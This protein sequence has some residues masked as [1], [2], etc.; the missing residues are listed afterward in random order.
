MEREP[1]VRPGDQPRRPRTP[2]RPG[3]PPQQRHRVRAGPDRGDARRP[4][5]WRRVGRRHPPPGTRPGEDRLRRGRR[6]H[7]PDGVRLPPRRAG[8]ERR[9]AR[10]T[11]S[12]RPAAPR[13]TRRRR[14]TPSAGS[15]SGSSST[16]RTSTWRCGWRRPA[17]AAGSPPDARAIHAYSASLGAGAGRKYARTGWSPRLHAAPL[18]G[19]VE[20]A[21]GRCGRSPA[22][23]RSAPASCCST[24]PA[25]GSRAGSRAGGPAPASS[26]ARSAALRCS[27]SAPAR[28][29]GSGAAGAS[30]PASQEARLRPAE[31]AQRPRPEPLELAV[32]D[33]DPA[34]E[35]MD[36]LAQ[37]DQRCV[38]LRELR[39]GGIAFL[40]RS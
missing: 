8:R 2:G 25:A 36:L 34:A 28:R 35:L 15:T 17:L 21:A 6:R 16:T 13:S 22:R 37:L 39:L 7:D 5:R 10:P 3:D 23:A 33:L 26:A 19:D 27:R 24:A 40:G 11:R 31:Q 4:R 29:F 38:L 32:L 14:S 9:R 1:R 12:G 20:P 18:R 30:R